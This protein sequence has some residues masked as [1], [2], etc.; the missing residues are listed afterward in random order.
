M[1]VTKTSRRELIGEKEFKSNLTVTDPCYDDD[2]WCVKRLDITPGIYNCYVWRHDETIKDFNGKPYTYT[3]IDRIEISLKDKSET[4]SKW[5]LCGEI[6]VD[7][8]FAGFFNDKPNHNDDEWM[9]F[10]DRIKDGFAWFE[11]EGFFSRSGMGDGVYAVL[12]K[13]DESG[14]IWAVRIDFYDYI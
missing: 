10:C 14:K 3:I 2:V 12:C 5:I 9:D 4:D 7:S 1:S 8:G 13:K 11:P 6:G